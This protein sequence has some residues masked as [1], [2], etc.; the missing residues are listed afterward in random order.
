[1]GYRE[2]N[3]PIAYINRHDRPL[4]LY[5]FGMDR[6]AH[7]AVLSRTISGGVSP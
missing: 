3:E 7:D 2:T 1:M 6:P 5:W 4:A